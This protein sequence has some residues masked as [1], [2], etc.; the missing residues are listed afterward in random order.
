MPVDNSAGK[1][2]DKHAAPLPDNKSGLFG[3]DLFTAPIA[4]R[5]SVGSRRMGRFSGCHELLEEI[6]FRFF[7]ATSGVKNIFLALAASSRTIPP[8][9]R[10]CAG[11]GPVATTHDQATSP[12]L[13]SFSAARSPDRELSPL[14]PCLRRGDT[15]CV[16]VQVGD[17]ITNAEGSPKGSL[18][19]AGCKPVKTWRAARQIKST[20][21]AAPLPLTERTK[22]KTHYNRPVS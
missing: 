18:Q 12:A 10:P 17:A 9:R 6:F 20:T 8:Q 16:V 5:S 11:R 14:G 19:E 13:Q 1:P 22:N 2:V 3:E 4:G 7:F 21:A 15:L